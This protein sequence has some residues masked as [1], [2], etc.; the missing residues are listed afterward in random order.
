MAAPQTT[1]KMEKRNYEKHKVR[2]NQVNLQHSRA[3]K[4]LHAAENHREN[5]DFTNTK[6]YLFQ[7]RLLGITK[8]YRTVI[9]GEGKIRAAIVLSDS[10]IDDLLIT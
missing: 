9:A 2:C 8:R 3:A 5:R 10:T 7:G 4:E 6:T 1:R